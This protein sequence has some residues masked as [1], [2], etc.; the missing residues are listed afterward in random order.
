M[1]DPLI[2]N[3]AFTG[4]VS[5][6]TRNPAVP[7]STQ[8]IHAD[9]VACAELGTSMGHFHVRD[10][11]GA[12]SC[13]AGRYG[14]L[15]STLRGDDR[16]RQMVLVASTSGRHGQTL[17]QRGAVLDLPEDIRPDM[18]SLTLSS[19]NFATGASINTPDGIRALAERMLRQG[20]KPELEIFDLGMV[21]FAHKLIAEGLLKPPYFFNVIL[22]NE[23]G[24]QADLASVAAILA[25]MPG[26]SYVSLG[27]IARA[28]LPAHLL[29]LSCA[30]GVRTGLED[31]LW[32]AKG[33]MA[34]NAS[35][36]ERI[37]Q[38]ADLSLRPVASPAELRQMLGL[39]AAW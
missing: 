35:L 7:Y 22:G 1:T 8:E 33:Q 17:E 29:A 36:V 2:I 20:V 27:G 39:R 15:F 23:A 16:L 11:D 25:Q 13:D 34:T 5:D 14:R 24:A 37:R 19:L 26:Q 18:A 30:S 12:P 31:N 4:A 32:L 3:T 9:A 28:Q 6:K 21:A 10:D 38:L